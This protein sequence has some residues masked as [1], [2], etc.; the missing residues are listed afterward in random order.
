MVAEI[1]G[2]IQSLTL[3]LTRLR[4]KYKEGH[5]EVQK[6]Q[7]QLEQLRKDKEARVAQIEE[8]LR[9]EYRQLQRREAELRAGDRRP[10]GPGRR[11]EPKL[12]ELESLKKQA[13]SAAGLYGVLLQKLNETN[14]AASIQNNN[15]RLL[16]RAVVPASPVWPR[17]RQ[18]VAGG[19]P[20]GAAAGSGLG[21]AAGRAR[22]HAQGRGRRRAAPAPRAAR[23]DS[24]LRQGRRDA[25]DRGLPEPPDRRFSSR[26]ART[27]A[28]GARHR[29]RAGRGQDHDAPATWAEAPRRRRGE[30]GGGR[31]R[32]AQRQPAPA[33]Q[34]L[35]GSP[36][37]P[38][39]SCARST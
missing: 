35:L 21:P 13:D 8:G 27:G 17:K 11:A 16:D 6:V 29:H 22:Q 2:S 19:A 28:G 34:R 7:V 25:R 15:V 33:P 23:R 5:P 24:P 26:G 14:I 36:D 31:L 3:D 30:R 10:Q 39:T 9:A 12:T 20:R 1:N 32:P 4:E 38:T 37:S 18:L